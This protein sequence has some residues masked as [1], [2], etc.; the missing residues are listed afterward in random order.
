MATC[1]LLALMVVIYPAAAHHGGAL[2][3]NFE[4]TVGPV[5]GT[6]TQFGFRFPHVQI[7]VDMPSENGE[8]QN[9]VFITRWTPTILRDHGWRRTSI[10]PGDKIT[11]TYN[12]HLSN[13][14][15]GTI[16]NLEVNGELLATD[17]N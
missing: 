2:E 10:E 13:P 16:I 1:A 14:T 11:V 12:P 15:A 8:M 7:F 4:E 17:F 5:T 3:W 6:A 9:F